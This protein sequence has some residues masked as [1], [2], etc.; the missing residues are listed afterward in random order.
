MN[1]IIGLITAFAAEDWIEPSIKQALNHCDEVIVSTGAYADNLEPF[2]D[3]TD[4]IC[5]RYKDRIKIV[6]SVKSGRHIG[7]KAGTLNN[8][9]KASKLREV[10]NWVWLFDVDEF[11]LDS[12]LKD[13]KT[14]IFKNTNYNTV[15]TNEMLFFIN[16]Q[17]Y[18]RTGINRGRFNK[19]S[20]IND[21]Y[22]GVNKWSG[23]R[24]VPLNYKGIGKFHYS[25]LKD[26]GF[27]M[28]LHLTEYGKN[29]NNPSK[30]QADKVRW[31]NEIYLKYELDNEDYWINKNQQMFGSREPYMKNT[32]FNPGR[33][34]HL[35]TY[36][37]DHPQVIE[38][39]G[40]TK[41]KDFRNK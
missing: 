41:I 24:N 17:K 5:Q 38:E 4:E 18:L 15:I 13:I 31:L 29:P 8:M 33:N 37:G 19:I 14:I 28:A 20:S 10:G 23:P 25:F 1:K 30:A 6:D 36:L 26:S 16:T 7:S 40:L 9:L 3:S 32:N 11:F 21:S 39:A 34:G 2:K 35:H 27:K 22:S 12:E